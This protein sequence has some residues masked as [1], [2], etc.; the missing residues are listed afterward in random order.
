MDYILL[1]EEQSD[2]EYACDIYSNSTE[3]LNVSLLTA[4]EHSESALYV[5][6][7]QID[8]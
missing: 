8:L 5:L 3:S 2:D 1:M 6:H 7:L 4:E